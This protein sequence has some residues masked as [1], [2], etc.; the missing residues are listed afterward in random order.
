MSNVLSS[1]LLGNAEAVSI[2]SLG[3]V[4]NSG[5]VFHARFADGQQVT[6]QRSAA[7]DAG[8]GKPDPIEQA[9]ADAFAEGFDAGMRIA[10]ENLASDEEVR[11]RLGHALDQLVPAANGALS[12]LLSAAVI[13]LVTQ[14]VGETPIDADLLARRVEAVAAFIDDSQSRSSL[15]LNPEDIAL[16]DGREIGFVLTPDSDVARGGVRLETADGWIE[17]G[18]DVQISRLKAMLDDME[19]QR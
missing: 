2:G 9:R 17:D 15:H 14:I 1:S 4:A 10:H 16:L 7:D 11:T 8:S 12:S 19:G 13:R 18:P 6:R 5:G 3:K